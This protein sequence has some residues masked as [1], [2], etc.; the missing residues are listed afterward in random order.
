MHK[1]RS[2]LQIRP[3]EER[4][5]GLLIALF[6]LPYFGAAIG[7]PGVEALFYARFGVEFLPYMYVVLGAITLIISFVL[8]SLLGRMSMKRFYLALPLVLAGT[9]VLSRI[10]VG[11]DLNWFYPVL[12]LGMYL[13]WT[14]HGMF[15]WGLAGTLCDTRQ[16][17][18]L[19]P[20]FGAGGILGIAL[21]GIAASLLVGLLGTE[22]LLLVWSGTLIGTFGVIYALAGEMSEPRPVARGARPGW[23]DEIKKGYRYVRRTA[24][25][26]WMAFGTILFSVLYFIIDFPFAKSVAAQFPDEDALT[27]FLGVFSGLIT[28]VAFLM[29]LFFTNRLFARIGFINTLILFS[30]IYLA[31]FGGAMALNAAFIPLVV[32]RFTQEIWLQAVADTAYQSSLNIVPE[33]VR[34]QTR[35]FLRGV[36]EQIGVSLAGIILAAGAGILTDQHFLAIGIVA[37]AANLFMVWRAGRFYRE[38]LVDA[39]RGGQPQIFYSEEEPFGGFHQDA[40][41]VAII[42]AGVADPN[43]AIRQVSVEILGNMAVPSAAPLL[44][45]A[46]EDFDPAVRRAALKALGRARVASALLEIAASLHDISPD[47]RLEAVH[48]LREMAQ[49]PRGLRMH[50]APLL[51]D[52]EPGVRAASAATLLG[53][54]PYPPAEAVLHQMGRAADPRERIAALEAFALWGNASGYEAAARALSDPQ[55]P[56]R[57][58]AVGA[59]A[60]IAPEDS[61]HLLVRALGDEDQSVRETV[62]ATLGG[63][64][65]AIL[66]SIV[67]ALN[68]PALEEGALLVLQQLPAGHMA[69]EL[70][71]YAR[72]KAALALCYAGYWA[73]FAASTSQSPRPAMALL[74]TA[75]YNR[76]VQHAANALQ[77]VGVLDDPA[78]MAITLENLNSRNPAQRANALEMLDS[79]SEREIIRPLLPL[80][81]PDT[82]AE[83][84]IKVDPATEEEILLALLTGTDP[85]LCA[86]AILS[87]AGKDDPRLREVLEHLRDTDDP[88][89]TETANYVL[90]GATMDTLTTIPM[91]ERILYLQK[92]P[93]FESLALAN[94]KQIAALAGE[95]LFPDGVTI[96]RQG[97]P[98][99]EMYIIVSGEVDISLRA[100]DGTEKWVLHRKPGDYVGEMSI[101][102]DEPRT[103]TLVA[104]GDVRALGV[105]QKP[106]EGMLRECPDISL[107]LIRELIFRLRKQSL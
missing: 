65:V 28:I 6:L 51:K 41:A 107:A 82:R 58:E 20:L 27:G 104:R 71:Q 30:L 29:S 50:L 101:L 63:R 55:A 4:L 76:A 96:A 19:F 12:W 89:I 90:N 53:Y 35:T 88:L 93:L 103:A 59:L 45:N 70:L 97:E 34:E 99:D 102:S 18:R 78:G 73:K 60:K 72:Q 54:G 100:E 61:Q 5:V 66:S 9:L 57:K 39:L 24:L 98:G 32:F 3:G 25:M 37:S 80:W 95:H 31:G 16:A 74:I 92:V 79:F 62:A 15:T 77:A 14:L 33:D 56:V 87:A 7:S 10:L 52:P 42:V 11:M 23:L 106:F 2:L 8:S 75:L 67:A 40:Q 84:K 13:L 69:N 83:G 46:L 86:C 91:M 64:G 49:H 17:K 81:E 26:R 22:N 36:P 43:P 1:L 44:V 85:W 105:K 47:V 68:D 94:L 38:A 48:T 21:G